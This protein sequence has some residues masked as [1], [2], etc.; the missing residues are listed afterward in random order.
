MKI[1]ITGSNGQ[2]GHEFQVIAKDDRINVYL[3]TDIGELNITDP[4]A[5]TRFIQRERPEVIVNCAGYTAVDKAENEA[6]NAMMINGTA[7]E[8][9]AKAANETDS[10]LLHI[11]TDYVFD[12]T[13]HTPYQEDHPVNPISIYAKSKCMGEEA[14]FSFANRGVIIRTSWLYSSFGHNF[15]KTILRYGRERGNLDVLYDQIGTPTYARDLCNAI[16]EILPSLN[17]HRG[18]GLFHYSNEGVASWYDFAKAII[19]LSDINCQVHPI[20]SKDYPQP[21][22]RPFYSVLNKA[23]FRNRFGISIPYWRDSLRD[24]I[25]KLQEER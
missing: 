1:L 23:K 14:V 4:E 2:M 3:F 7:V 18:V 17:E 9:L 21:A 15:V 5:V 12:G 16:A 8:I 24:C 20:E 10:I 19:E 11:S 22:Q 25:L 6:G 13:A